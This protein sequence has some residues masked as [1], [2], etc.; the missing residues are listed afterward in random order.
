MASGDQAPLLA[1][2]SAAKNG[3][4]DIQDQLAQ[5]KADMEARRQAEAVK[6]AP[7]AAAPVAASA[8]AA[9]SQPP[10][11]QPPPPA[12]QNTFQS[13]AVDPAVD[14][15]PDRR[16]VA[17][18]RTHIGSR[19]DERNVED[20]YGYDWQIRML[21]APCKSPLWFCTSCLC[22]CCISYKQRKDIML[23]TGEPYKCCGGSI[24][25]QS[26]AQLPE[27]PCLCLE[28]TCC[29]FTSIMVNRYMIR[30]MYQL[31]LDPCDEYLITLACIISWV[32]CL[33]KLF[34]VIEEDSTLEQLADC[35]ILSVMGCSLTQNQ[36]ELA[37]HEGRQM[38]DC[39]FENTP[40]NNTQAK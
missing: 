16:S 17:G 15:N 21:D 37:F 40:Y 9:S 20:G 2:D 22:G 19:D 27:I 13:G 30:D 29:T 11:Q 5:R 4:T 3:A 1:D 38:F 33:L 26:T 31:Q 12:A 10:A 25:G 18:R 39:D 32:I 24:C 8:V 23:I 34:G 35:F 7:P 36:T 14:D 28:V 6:N